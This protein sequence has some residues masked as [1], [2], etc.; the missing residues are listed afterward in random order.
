MSFKE[1]AKAGDQALTSGICTINLVL[2][3]WVHLSYPLATLAHFSTA[4]Y[5]CQKHSISAGENWMSI[6]RSLSGWLMACAVRYTVTLADE[7]NLCALAWNVSRILG[8][9]KWSALHENDVGCQLHLNLQNSNE[10]PSPAHPTSDRE[11]PQG[12]HT[13]PCRGH[14]KSVTYPTKWP[15]TV[16][17]LS[18]RNDNNFNVYFTEI[19]AVSGF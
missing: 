4:S 17:Y 11:N 5:S 12:K 9:R 2:W 18:V 3:I 10:D 19:I 8:A 15:L 1:T 13:W 7:V 16:A 14:P 6:H